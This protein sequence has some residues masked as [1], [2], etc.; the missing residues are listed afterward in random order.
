M[1][2]EAFCPT[3]EAYRATKAVERMERY[4]VRG[5]DIEVPVKVEVC[6]ECGEQLG[7]D[8]QDKHVLD[9]AY[10]ECRQRMDLLQGR[11]NK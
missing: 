11:D 10:A 2:N 1:K 4:K 3:C 9:T 6:A 8:E 7:S 5:L